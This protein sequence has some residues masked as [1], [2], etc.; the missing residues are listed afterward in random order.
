MEYTSNY[1]IELDYKRAGISIENFDTLESAKSRI[2][3]LI[4]EGIDKSAIKLFQT[5]EIKF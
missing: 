3:E 4:F 2:K 5:N 1:I